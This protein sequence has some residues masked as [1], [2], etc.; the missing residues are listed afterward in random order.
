MLKG[1]IEC[2]LITLMGFLKADS[3]EDGVFPGVYLDIRLI[4]G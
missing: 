4:L 3:H 2:I 1:A